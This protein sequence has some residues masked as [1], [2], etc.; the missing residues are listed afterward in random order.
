MLIIARNYL[1]G[2]ISSKAFFPRTLPMGSTYLR[3][4]YL[5][6]EQRVSKKK[7]LFRICL[8]VFKRSLARISRLG[9]RLIRASA[10]VLVLLLGV[11]LTAS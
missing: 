6:R 11:L 5:A 7:W 2:F 4:F 8:R 1:W 10:R 3:A 9:F